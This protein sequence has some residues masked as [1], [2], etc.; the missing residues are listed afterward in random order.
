MTLKRREFLRSTVVSAGTITMTAPFIQAEEKKINRRKV[1]STDPVAMVPLTDKITCTRIGLGT[2]MHGFNRQ[3]NLTRLGTEKAISIIRYA[4]DRGIRLFDCADAYGTHGLVREAL[5]DKP[6]DSYTIISKIWVN[7]NGGI[8]EK[9]RPASEIV[10]KRFL[11]ELNTDYIDL[12]QL[13]CMRNGNWVEEFGRYFDELEDLKQKGLIRGHGITCHALTS[14][15]KAIAL[16]WVDA[17]HVRMNSEGAHMDGSWE[18]NAAAVDAC[19]DKGKGIVIMKVLG[20]GLFKDAAVRRRSIDKILRYESADVM[21]VGFANN[22]EIDEFL[23][24]TETSLKAIAA[25]KAKV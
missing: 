13:H 6:R 11:K 19:H 23:T 3:S 1:N 15:Q 18:D 10:I 5:A 21:V 20:Q 7:K 17:L 12:L 8:P 2:G 24:N 25:E 22:G 9:E 14:V 16:P 4:Y